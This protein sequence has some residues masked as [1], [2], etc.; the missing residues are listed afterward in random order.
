MQNARWHC[1]VALVGMLGILLAH[2]LVV[3]QPASGASSVAARPARD[4]Q[5]DFDFEI[6][7][8]KTH[9]SRLLRPLPYGSS[10]PFRMTEAKRGN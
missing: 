9:L 6:G 7:T 2:H 4:G 1:Q 10:S 8:W 5:A 3:A